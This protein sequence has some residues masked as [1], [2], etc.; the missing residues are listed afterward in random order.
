MAVIMPARDL[1]KL[2]ELALLSPHPASERFDPQFPVAMKCSRCGKIA[3][4]PRQAMRDA[5]V[6]H[7][8][9]DCPARHT[10][11]DQPKEMRLLYPRVKE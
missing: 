1:T 2:E 6:A 4:G 10:K 11:A 5:M 7:W 3:Y 8:E 9:E